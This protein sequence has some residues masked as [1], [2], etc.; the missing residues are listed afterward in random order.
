MRLWDPASGQEQ[1]TLTGHTGSVRGVA[2]APDDRLLASG[3]E[4]QA[5]KLW[6][7]DSHELAG[8]LTGHT[9]M[10]SA[11]AFARQTL[12]STSW[13]QRILTWDVAARVTRGNLDT[14]AAVV[15]LA[16][17]PEGDRLLTASAGQSLALWRAFIVGGPPTTGNEVK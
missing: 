11:V 12:V 6:N 3:G 17:A 7:V 8:T 13:D 4:D 15:A 9:D 2:F 5:I 1:A 14:G 16:V 10:V